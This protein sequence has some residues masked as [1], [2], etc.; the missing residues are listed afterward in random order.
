M[1]VVPVEVGGFDV[2]G[3]PTAPGAAGERGEGFF[4][5]TWSS[6]H[7][8]F[9]RLTKAGAWHRLL[10][11]AREEART[12]SGKKPKPNAADI[13]ARGASGPL[14]R[15]A[16]KAR[17]TLKLVWLDKGCTGPHY[18]TMP[19]GH[20]AFFFPLSSDSHAMRAPIHS[21]RRPPPA[22]ASGFPLVGF[23]R[24]VCRVRTLRT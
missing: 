3:H 22:V 10:K 15:K 24:H 12:R 6:K 20:L 7:R 21:N 4:T 8:T 19:T 5:L 11:I 17:P 13:Q 14:I 18:E 16:K 2:Q 23:R 9:L 1:A